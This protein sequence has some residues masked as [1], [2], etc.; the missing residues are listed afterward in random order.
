MSL[1]PFI[2]SLVEARMFYGVKDIKGMS[3]DEI[4]QIVFLMF[5]MLEV[6]RHYKPNY[7]AD[8][9]RDTL[10]YNTYDQLHYSGSDLGNLLAVLNNQDTF[11]K[12]IKTHIGVSIPLFQINRYLGVLASKTKSKSSHNDDVTFFWRLED[13]LKLSSNSLLRQ[14]R[15]DI[16]NWDDL[17]RA[18]KQ[19]IYYILRREF[20]KRCSSA[21]IYLWYKS[22][23]KITESSTVL[24]D[25]KML[26]ELADAPYPFKYSPEY[27]NN[28]DSL[29]PKKS[30]KFKTDS[31]LAYLVTVKY[32]KEF[33]GNENVINVLFSL[34]KGEEKSDLSQDIE[35]TGDAFR[36]F[37]TI[38][39]ILSLI[40]VDF[41]RENKSIGAIYFSSKIDLPSRNKLYDRFAKS[42]SKYFPEFEF[43]SKLTISEGLNTWEIVRKIKSISI[44]E[45]SET[46]RLDI[47]E[48]GDWNLRVFLNAHITNSAKN[49]IDRIGET[50]AKRGSA[51]LDLDNSSGIAY[52][53]RID[54]TPTG[55]GFGSEL[56]KYIVEQ[57]KAHGYYTVKAYTE[58]TNVGS[59]DMFKKAGFKSVDHNDSGNYWELDL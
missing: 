47:E 23:F 55:Q 29:M 14:L 18:D 34:I 59:K 40:L 53:N 1:L 3:A 37:A 15:R 39:E 41:D 28:S 10:K 25:N 48:K 31:G 17:S 42:I 44:K 22:E 46:E 36:I 38:K 50:Q 33:R 19:Q 24:E 8:Y 26:T 57:S 32:A 49:W 21:D 52:I 2:D 13:Y 35:N 56:L 20:D 9:A 11:K 5:M 4:A 51:T 6:I 45:S 54:A 27:S 30:Y 58:W 12:D 16:G 7:T 43:K